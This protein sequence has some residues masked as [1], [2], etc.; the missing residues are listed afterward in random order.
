[1]RMYIT[2]KSAKVPLRVLPKAHEGS[3]YY[4]LL[5]SSHSSHT[6]GLLTMAAQGRRKYVHSA[7]LYQ[8]RGTYASIS[9]SGC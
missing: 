7:V 6:H 9:T 4:C 5:A 3:K 8:V 2:Q 1:M